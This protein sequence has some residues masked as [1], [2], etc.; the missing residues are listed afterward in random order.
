MQPLRQDVANLDCLPSFIQRAFEHPLISKPK[1]I[2]LATY[3]GGSLL[4]NED[5]E[6]EQCTV[7]NPL[8]HANVD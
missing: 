3:G 5:K 4:L 7:K 1:R 6:R 8:L 2:H